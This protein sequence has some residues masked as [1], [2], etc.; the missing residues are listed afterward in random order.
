MTAFSDAF[1]FEVMRMARKEIKG[2]LGTLRKTVTAQRSEIAALKR[3]LKVLTSQVRTLTNVQEKTDAAAERPQAAQRRSK[4]L[5]G[6]QPTQVASGGLEAAGGKARGGHKSTFSHEALIAKRH[7]LHLT[8][9][10]MARLLGVSVVSLYKWETGEVMPRAA[11]LERVRKV[12]K[13]GVRA[14][15]KQIAE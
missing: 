3:D 2:E 7:A 15:R 1:R 11:Q 4:T 8:Q 10:D 6:S 5:S 14:A 12:L 13:M 9:K